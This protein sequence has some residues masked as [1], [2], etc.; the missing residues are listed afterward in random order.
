MGVITH[1]AELLQHLWELR[2]EKCQKGGFYRAVSLPLPMDEAAPRALLGQLLSNPLGGGSS[3][4]CRV[5]QDGQ[6]YL[7]PVPELALCTSTQQW[8]R[9]PCS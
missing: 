7:L 2:H 5:P 9:Q 8:I 1:R 6:D 3:Q 4:H